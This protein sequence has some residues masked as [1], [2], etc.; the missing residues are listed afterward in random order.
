MGMTQT[1]GKKKMT[2]FKLRKMLEAAEEAE[3]DIRES[4][5]GT[6]SDSD[7]MLIRVGKLSDIGNVIFDMRTLIESFEF[8]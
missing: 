3:K 1:G 8:N 5:N 4:L 6:T 7:T 2:I